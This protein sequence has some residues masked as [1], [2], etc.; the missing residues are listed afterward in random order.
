ML[1]TGGGRLPHSA[2][3]V[4]NF[5]AALVRR[6]ERVRA[7]L[8]Q[9]R[10]EFCSGRLRAGADYRSGDLP[11]S[12]Q[13]GHLGAERQ[14]AARPSRV[15]ADRDR[16]AAVQ[17]AQQ[18]P[19]RPDCGVRVRIAERVEHLQ[20][21]P[22]ARVD[23]NRQRAL[24]GRRREQ[25]RVEKFGDGVVQAEA[26]EAR[27]REDHRVQPG[28]NLCQ[29]G[30]YVAAD[31]HD[32]DVGAQRLQLRDPPRGP[33]ADPRSGAQCLQSRPAQCVQRVGARRGHGEHQPVR[34]RGGKVL[35]RVDCDVDLPGEQFLLKLRGE[36]AARASARPQLSSRLGALPDP[37]A[38]RA[39][40][41]VHPWVR[42]V[43]QGRGPGTVPTVGALRTPFEEG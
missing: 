10:R 41:R 28:L 5:P 34:R 27:G 2:E 19:L 26:P 21:F 11:L 13:G 12:V 8:L 7:A 33:G 3:C 29:A 24:T 6:L 15:G 35:Q 1:A 36:H 23:L 38:V 32:L 17:F 31:R 4:P 39:G 18:E 37:G 30:R 14:H 20:Q 43:R 42:Q 22:V 16:A 25:G 9:D 40:C